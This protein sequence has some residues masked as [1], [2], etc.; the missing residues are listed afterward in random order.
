[1]IEERGLW[2]KSTSRSIELRAVRHLDGHGAD[3]PREHPLPELVEPGHDLELAPVLA[4][5]GV[6]VAGPPDLAGGAG[7]RPDD[8]VEVAGVNHLAPDGELAAEDVLGVGGGDAGGRVVGVDEAPVLGRGAPVAKGVVRVEG[9]AVGEV[10]PL[11][12]A[13]VE[14]LFEHSVNMFAPQGYSN[15][16]ARG[17]ELT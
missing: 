9:G 12:A 11:P 7:A 1:M 14:V 15:S 2:E 10:D 3:A 17:S 8:V 5:G 13:A 4:G 16:C 6:D